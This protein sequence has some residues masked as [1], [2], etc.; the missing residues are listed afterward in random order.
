LFVLILRFSPVPLAEV[1][2]QVALHLRALVGG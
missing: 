2:V 1:V